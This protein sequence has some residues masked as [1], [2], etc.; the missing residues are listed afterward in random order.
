VACWPWQLEFVLD[1]DRPIRICPRRESH[2]NTPATGESLM[3]VC[4]KAYRKPA[5]FCSII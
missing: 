3:A 5:I 2:S 4:I 1:L